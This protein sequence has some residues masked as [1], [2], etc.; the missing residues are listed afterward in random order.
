MR[1]ESGNV[2]SAGAAPTVSGALDVIETACEKL[3]HEQRKEA[4]SLLSIFVVGLRQTT[5]QDILEVLG[6]AGNTP[7]HP[8]TETAAF[9]GKPPTGKVDQSTPTF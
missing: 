1:P 2:S 9:A 6:S 8:A 7:A 3:G 4:A 5:K